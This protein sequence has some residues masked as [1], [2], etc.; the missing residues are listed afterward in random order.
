MAISSLLP[1]MVR[2]THCD[3]L[4]MKPPQF[5]TVCPLINCWVLVLIMKFLFIAAY[6]GDEDTPGQYST[7]TAHTRTHGHLVF[8]MRAMVWNMKYCAL[9]MRTSRTC[10]STLIMLMDFKS[11]CGRKNGYLCRAGDP[12]YFSSNWFSQLFHHNR[13][14]YCIATRILIFPHFQGSCFS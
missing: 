9:M 2:A 6:L 5:R 7:T 11:W 14:I 8:L 12:E 3:Y 1:P 13:A 10:V 4:W